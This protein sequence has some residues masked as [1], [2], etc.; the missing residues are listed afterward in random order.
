MGK[1]LPLDQ[2]E[3]RPQGCAG[4]HIVDQRIRYTVALAATLNAILTQNKTSKVLKSQGP[5]FGT[6][7][8]QVLIIMTVILH[9]GSVAVW[10]L[11]GLRRTRRTGSCQHYWPGLKG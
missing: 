2:Q 8:W 9:H 5:T 1:I 7:Y 4:P 10:G 6:P 3:R 11:I